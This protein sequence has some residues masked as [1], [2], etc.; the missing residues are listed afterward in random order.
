MP[1][2]NF[3]TNR[4]DQDTVGLF[5]PFRDSDGN[6]ISDSKNP[7]L[8]RAITLYTFLRTAYEKLGI[9]EKGESDTKKKV[10]LYEIATRSLAQHSEYGGKMT[11]YVEVKGADGK[12]IRVTHAAIQQRLEKFHPSL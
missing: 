8:Q 4:L 6:P 12:T 10:R 7:A 3:K 11:D 1:M 2:R 5:L 9:L